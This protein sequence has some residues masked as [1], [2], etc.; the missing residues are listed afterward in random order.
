MQLDINVVCL[1]QEHGINDNPLFNCLHQ[2][3]QGICNRLF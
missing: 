2:Y 1:A 3:K